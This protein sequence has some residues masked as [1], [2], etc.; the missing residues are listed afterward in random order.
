LAEHE[1]LLVANGAGCERAGIA[2]DGA[3]ASFPP[4]A[5]VSTGFCGALA[6]EMGAAEVVVATE[7]VAG[8]SRYPAAP[9]SSRAPH[10]R[11]VVCTIGHIAQTAAE[12][13]ALRRTGASAVEM[14]AAAVALRAHVRGLPFYCI[15]AVTDLAA[16]TLANDF[17]A[18]LRSDGHLDTIRILGS[19]LR[20]PRVRIPELLRLRNRSIR[21]AHTLGDFFANCRF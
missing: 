15:K 9:V 19:A 17:N 8:D 7:V 12:K 13:R 4:D 11:G 21:A 3:L 18:A 16:E 1:L 5:L 6:P 10:H 20:Q 14:E 2:V